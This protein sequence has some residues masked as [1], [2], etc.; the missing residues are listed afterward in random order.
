M[1]VQTYTTPDGAE[2][3]SLPR[4]EY[5]NLV[6]ARD[7]AIAMRNVAAGAPVLT[8]AELDAFLAAASPL[9][10]WR[11]RAGMTQTALARK[12]GITQA[13]L[14]QIEAGSRDGTVAV[15]K[16]ISEALGL[17]IEDLIAD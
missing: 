6:D 15:L 13:F 12:V 5:Q 11:K 14:A 4:S 8:E 16:R 10:F 17:R 1:D 9:A 3:V 2:R 7:H